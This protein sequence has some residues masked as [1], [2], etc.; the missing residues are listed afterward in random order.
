MADTANTLLAR[1]IQDTST[2]NRLDPA[3]AGKLAILL[4]IANEVRGLLVVAGVLGW[5]S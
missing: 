1:F 4:L 5:W 3:T 2:G